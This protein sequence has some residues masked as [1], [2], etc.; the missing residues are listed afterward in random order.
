MS[1]RNIVQ[2]FRDS[3]GAQLQCTRMLGPDQRKV[4][5]FSLFGLCERTRFAGNDYFRTLGQSYTLLKDDYATLNPALYRHTI[6]F[7]WLL[8]KSQAETSYALLLKPLR[9][10]FLSS[11][12]TKCNGSSG[13]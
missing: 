12:G 6:I 4:D 11:F 5:A 7:C 9:I 8:R 13:S 1:G 3:F 2:H 10:Y